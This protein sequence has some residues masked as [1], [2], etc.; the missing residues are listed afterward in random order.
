VAVALV[1][2]RYGSHGTCEVNGIKLHYVE[3][4]VAFKG[5]GP[6]ILFLHGFPEV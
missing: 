1:D 4:G 5:Q 6:A 3:T 2:P